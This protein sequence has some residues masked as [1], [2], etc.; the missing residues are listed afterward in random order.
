MDPGTQMWMGFTYLQSD[1]CEGECG[2]GGV[3]VVRVVWRAAASL[4]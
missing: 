1:V 4:A 3:G 2:E